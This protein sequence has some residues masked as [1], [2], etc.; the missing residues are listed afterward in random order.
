MQLYGATAELL[1][2]GWFA[3]RKNYCRMLMC[4]LSF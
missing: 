1:D 2:V 3:P 4:E